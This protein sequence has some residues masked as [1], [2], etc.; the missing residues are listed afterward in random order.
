VPTHD[1]CCPVVQ[2]REKLES[3]NVKLFGLNAELVLELADG[4]S[5]HTGNLTRHDI[6]GSVDFGRSVPK[7]RVRAARVGPVL[8]SAQFVSHHNPCVEHELTSGVHVQ[9]LDSVKAR[10]CAHTS[11]SPSSHPLVAPVPHAL[12][13]QPL[14][15]ILPTCASAK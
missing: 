13:A 3:V 2:S 1:I 9:P 11:E 10:G 5:L 14:A 6:A 8:Q 12:S 4:C 7:K 15:H